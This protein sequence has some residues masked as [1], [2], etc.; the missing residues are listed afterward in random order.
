MVIQALRDNIPK[1]ITGVILALLVVPFALWG[2][3]S[4]FTASSDNSVAT[5]NGDPISPADFQRAY[6]NQYAQ[7][8][9]YYGQA[10]RPEMIDEK[11]MRQ[12]VLD[13]LI[14][15]TLLNQQV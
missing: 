5:V 8:Q 3:N 9:S 1:W 13:R 2:I 6:Q 15:E 12:Q 14:D 10:F 7:L 4:Y 11:Q